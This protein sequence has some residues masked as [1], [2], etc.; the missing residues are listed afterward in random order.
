ME[1][2]EKSPKKGVRIIQEWI[3]EDAERKAEGIAA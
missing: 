1:Q 3:E 2:L